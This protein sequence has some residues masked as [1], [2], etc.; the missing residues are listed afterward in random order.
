M[1]KY[2]DILAGE[3]MGW[4]LIN[5]AAENDERKYMEGLLGIENYKRKADW[6]SIRLCKSL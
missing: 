6:T 2:K 5:S 4:D 3:S 1:I